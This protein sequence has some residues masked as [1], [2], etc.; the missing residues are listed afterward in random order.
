VTVGAG[1][2]GTSYTAGGTSSFGAHAS[3]T[4]GAVGGAI[5]TYNGAAGGGAGGTG[6]SGN[7]NI[8]GKAGQAGRVVTTAS[9]VGGD[10]GEVV[11]YSLGSAG[12]GAVKGAGAGTVYGENGAAG[13]VIVENLF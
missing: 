8:T 3:A 9:Y 10:G 5:G 13:I 2:V 11:L 4:G 1:G 7:L 6:S 12:L